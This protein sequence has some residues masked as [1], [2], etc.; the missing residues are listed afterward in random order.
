MVAE[1]LERS[2]LSY[3]HH[4]FIVLDEDTDSASA[5]RQMHSKKAEIIIVKQQ[6][7][8]KFVGIFTDTDILDKVVVRGEDSDK[9]SVEGHNVISSHNDFGKD[10]C[11][12]GT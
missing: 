10:K 7:D 12:T 11:K 6:K 3:M 1:P 5:V 8:G 9:G 4:G 2:V